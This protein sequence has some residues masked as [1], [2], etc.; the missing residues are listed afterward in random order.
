MEDNYTNKHR[1]HRANT[2]PYSVSR[3]Q[4]QGLRRLH[5]PKH[6]YRETRDE[7]AVPK[8]HF[9]SSC[10]FCFCKTGGKSNFK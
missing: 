6:T 5:Q 3:T 1:T 4:W 10:F 7:S 8:V 2:R 9:T